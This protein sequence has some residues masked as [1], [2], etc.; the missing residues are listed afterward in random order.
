MVEEAPMDKKNVSIQGTRIKG[1]AGS[2]LCYPS[3]MIGGES[4]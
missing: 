3:S 1:K 2:I 4:G